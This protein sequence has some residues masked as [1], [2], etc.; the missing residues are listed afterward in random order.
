MKAFDSKLCDLRHNLEGKDELMSF[1]QEHHDEIKEVTFRGAE[2]HWKVEDIYT[3]WL[4]HR[5][6]KRKNEKKKSTL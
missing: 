4:H 2:Y 5:Q 6:A 1:I 3:F